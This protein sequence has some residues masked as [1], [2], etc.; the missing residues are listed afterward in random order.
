MVYLVVAAFADD[1]NEVAVA[2]APR[3]RL[4]EL[5]DPYVEEVKEE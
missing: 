4:K 1:R 5:V 2:V 3:E